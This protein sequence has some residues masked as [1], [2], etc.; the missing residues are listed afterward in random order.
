[1]I[2]GAPVAP[3]ASPSPAA[4]TPRRPLP[5]LPAGLY[6]CVASNG[7]KPSC[8][9]ESR[10]DTST[11]KPC[12][13]PTTT[14]HRPPSST[15]RTR[16]HLRRLLLARPRQVAAFASCWQGRRG[17]RLTQTGTCPTFTSPLHGRRNH[18]HNHNH[19]HSANPPIPPPPPAFWAPWTAATSQLK[20]RLL[21]ARARARC[22]A[23]T[24]A[25]QHTLPGDRP[26]ASCKEL[27]PVS[28]MPRSRG[29]RIRFRKGS[30]TRRSW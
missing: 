30:G 23:A 11:D 29:G 17:V 25:Q 15:K 20:S 10:P 18:N 16:Q 1:V 3:S 8:D 21:P 22:R 5:P 9:P 6:S 4:R 7:S 2:I 24:S 26:G 27:D 14:D 28:D 13:R 12:Q 19:N